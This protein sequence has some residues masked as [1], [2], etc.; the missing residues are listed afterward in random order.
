MAR[1]LIAAFSL[2]LRTSLVAGFVL[3][4]ISGNLRA[5]AGSSGSSH[6]GATP[7]YYSFKDANE[8]KGGGVAVAWVNQTSGQMVA[9]EL[10]AQHRFFWKP[11]KLKISTSGRYLLA[12]SQ[13]VGP[14]NLLL[15]DLNAGTHQFLTVDR[16][17]DDVAAWE[18]MFVIGADEQMCYIVD[19]AQGKVAHRWNGKHQ[20]RP[21]GRRIEYVAT[22]ADGTAWSS[23]QKDSAS[24]NG[25][26]SRVVTIDI[27]SGKTIA[28]LQMPRALPNLNLADRKER[29]PNP[30][31]IIPSTKSNTLLLSMDLY[32]GV[33]LADLDAAREGAWKNLTYHP[34]AVDGSWGTAFPDRATVYAAGDREFVLIANA[35]VAGGVTWVDLAARAVVQTLE[36]PPGI[37]APVKL[38]GGRYLAAPVLGKAKERSFGELREGRQSLAELY[39]F[40]ISGSAASARISARS[41]AL[42]YEAELAA[43]ISA[44][45]DLVFLTANEG[46]QGRFLVVRAGSG[47]VTDQQVALGKISRIAF[48]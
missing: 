14:N 22:T 37:S 36:T 30:E 31:I 6:A 38:A 5:G 11:H 21:D 32:G 20:L 27:L 44:S 42:P 18:D 4:S 43:P 9:Q 34:V 46:D 12:T 16:M 40:E 33:A 29:G 45:S 24:G 7:I 48:R 25:K 8:I 19:A 47:A 1:P 3:A 17:P 39:V 41:V 10:I 15:A 26:G 2:F 35:G 13:H 28:D 23:W